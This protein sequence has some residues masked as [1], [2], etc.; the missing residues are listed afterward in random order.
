MRTLNV[1][2]VQVVLINVKRCKT[3]AIYANTCLSLLNCEF[4][5]MFIDM[6]S[7]NYH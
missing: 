3:F 7:R 6:C 1:L 2:K 5:N 4:L